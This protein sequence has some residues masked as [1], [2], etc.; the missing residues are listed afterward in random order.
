VRGEDAV[1]NVG[2]G[3]DGVGREGGQNCYEE[4]VQRRP[5]SRV[6]WGSSDIKVQDRR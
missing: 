4:G 5:H 1:L 3:E 6:G 2:G